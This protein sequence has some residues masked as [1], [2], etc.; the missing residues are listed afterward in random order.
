MSTDFWYTLVMKIP[1]T[2]NHNQ[3]AREFW[4][5]ASENQP[6][7]RRLTYSMLPLRGHHP[8]IVTGE[9]IFFWKKLLDF[10]VQKGWPEYAMIWTSDGELVVFDKYLLQD[11]RNEIQ[12]NR[13]R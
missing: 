13:I 10:L 2:F 5:W 1:K 6:R 4:R 7:H 11:V 8:K 3:V 9:K 12:R